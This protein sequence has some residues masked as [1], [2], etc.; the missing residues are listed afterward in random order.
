MKYPLLLTSLLVST[1][2][3]INV[4]AQNDVQVPEIKQR[5]SK[6]TIL[7]TRFSNLPEEKR[8]SYLKLRADAHRYFSNKR[9]FETLMALYEMRE[10]FDGD[11][12]AYNLQGAIYVE[13]RDFAKARETFKKAV[14]MAGEDP[15]V[16][17]N[18][19]ELEF[20]DN[21]WVSSINHFK[22]LLKKIKSQSDTEFARLVEFKIMLCKL[23]L[24]KS[25]DS[26]INDD[27]KKEYLAE[28]K[29][30]A[31][32]Y[33]YLLDSPYYYYAN[34]ALAFYEDDK[35]TASSWIITGKKVFSN[36]PALVTSWDDTMVEFGY[37]E[38]HYGKHHTESGDDALVSP[39]SDIK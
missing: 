21:Q 25:E 9:T 12:V 31:H 5:I 11:P 4:H 16:L 37:I 26:N 36:N 24:S 7:N 1:F 35:A 6:A 34:A 32:K 17:F 20:C 2:G 8:R 15:K 10:I 22:T 30:L 33:T 23:A 14:D 27:K 3:C 29:Q 28:A 38:A 18:L 39:E 13:F 19:A